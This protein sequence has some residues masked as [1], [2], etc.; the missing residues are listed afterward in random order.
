MTTRKAGGKKAEETTAVATTKEFNPAAYAGAGMQ[1]DMAADSLRDPVNI[2]VISKNSPQ[3]DEDSE[4]FIP[5][6]KQGDLAL[7]GLFQAFKELEFLPCKYE[8]M[9][10]VKK[11][12][13]TIGLLRV[14][15]EQSEELEDYDPKTFEALYT[16]PIELDEDG[17]EV[18]KYV[19]EKVYIV[20]YI[21]F[22]GMVLYEGFTFLPAILKTKRTELRKARQLIR[23]A[24]L[25]SLTLPDGKRIPAPL[26]HNF[27]RLTSGPEKNRKGSWR[28]LR[29]RVSRTLQ[30]FCEA[31]DM[32]PKKYYDAANSLQDLDLFSLS[33]RVRDPDENSED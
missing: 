13:T 25:Q 15:P 7:V 33:M 4:A 6:A 30:E 21:N 14:D 28:G 29:I 8:R 20:E 23:L 22:V 2:H 1:D 27:Y 9:W 12:R 3:V 31:S 19:N 24:R 26:F 5:E 17:D 16:S 11:K 10:A 18:Q 32:E